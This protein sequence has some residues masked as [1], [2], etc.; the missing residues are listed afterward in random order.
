MKCKRCRHTWTP[1][2]N[3]I[4]ICPKCKSPYWDIDKQIYPKSIKE[5]EEENK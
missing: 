2:I 5:L 1:R 4:T 3:K